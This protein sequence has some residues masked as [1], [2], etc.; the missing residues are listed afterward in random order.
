MKEKKGDC[1]CGGKWI[2]SSKGPPKVWGGG[3][4]SQGHRTSTTHKKNV[5]FLVEKTSSFDQKRKKHVANPPHFAS[6]HD[7]WCLS[8]VKEKGNLSENEGTR[9]EER[10]FFKKKR[11]MAH[12]KYS[13]DIANLHSP[14]KAP[15]AW[16]SVDKKRHVRENVG[17]KDDFFAFLFP[18]QSV[19]VEVYYGFYKQQ[20][21]KND[22]WTCSLSLWGEI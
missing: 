12:Q 21:H 19:M 7:W 11:G 2:F 1:F 14:L 22:H 10:F 16:K 15:V 5:A 3:M 8:H 6:P 20:T 17:C 4:L 9:E 18:F 13:L